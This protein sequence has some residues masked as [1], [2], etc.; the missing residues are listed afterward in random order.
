MFLENRTGVTR[1][2][3]AKKTQEMHQYGV[4]TNIKAKAQRST[5]R[6]KG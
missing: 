1:K 2:K 5:V 4:S 6:K 3:S